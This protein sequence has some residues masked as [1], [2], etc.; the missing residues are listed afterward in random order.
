M[1]AGPVHHDSFQGLVSADFFCRGKG[2]DCYF[3]VRDAATPGSTTTYTAPEEPNVGYE[4]NTTEDKTIFE[5]GQVPCDI[6]VRVQAPKDCTAT[7]KANTGAEIQLKNTTK[8]VGFA[9]ASK[10][11]VRCEGSSPTDER[12]KFELRAWCH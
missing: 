10:V 12:C 4:C 5:R 9:G 6:V 11:S 1:T 8:F 7:V 2:G 3:R